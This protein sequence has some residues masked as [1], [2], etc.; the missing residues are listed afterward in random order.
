MK[1]LDLQILHLIEVRWK[2]GGLF[3]YDKD[4]VGICS[5]EQ[6]SYAGIAVTLGDALKNSLTYSILDSVCEDNNV[7]TEDDSRGVNVDQ[8]YVRATVV[9]A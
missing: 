9:L 7:Q 1:S 4:A 2:N 8:M 6:S 3:K 5:V